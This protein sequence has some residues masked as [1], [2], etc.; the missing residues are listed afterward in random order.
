MSTPTA[1]ALLRL[2]EQGQGASSP[3]RAL[4]LLAAAEPEPSW[5]ALG[6]LP[7]G[8]RDGRLLSLRERLF[9]RTLTATAICPGC[10]ERVE[11]P[12]DAEALRVPEPQAREIEMGGFRFRL[13]NARDL[14]ACATCADVETAERRLL[15][16][17]LLTLE[18]PSEDD[19]ARIG[20]RM[21][22]ADP[23]ADLEL[24]LGCPACEAHWTESLDVA[25][26]LWTELQDWALRILR[27][28]HLLAATYG[29][30]EAD[31]LAL[32]PLRRR[33]YLE[34]AAP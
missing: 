24:D 19:R 3:E 5:D 21:A 2:W 4:L 31:I 7:L 6:D 27:D 17:C 9:G 13:P 25:D 20:A 23:G 15:D 1:D 33:L 32:S 10:G 29:W 18:S 28:V 8:V 16:R 30:R 26:F 22:E 14:L 12:L 34:M 11:L